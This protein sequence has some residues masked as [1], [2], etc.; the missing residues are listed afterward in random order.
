MTDYTPDPTPTKHC[1]SCDK[2]YPATAEYFATDRSKPDGFVYRCKTCANARTRVLRATLEERKASYDPTVRQCTRCDKVFPATLEYFYAARNN[3]PDALRAT[4][5]PCTGILTQEQRDPDK[6]RIRDRRYAA[7]NRDK[8][9]KSCREWRARNLDTQRKKDRI[10]KQKDPNR[11]E[12]VKA[13]RINNPDK[14]RLNMRLYFTRKASHA[15]DYTESD[16]QFA[17]D[18]FK[19]C[20]AVCGRPPGLFHGL[21]MD[22]WLPNSS[23]DCPG[24]IPANIVPLCNGT[25]GCNQSKHARDPVQWL[26]DKFGEKQGKAILARVHEFFS[27]VRSV[28]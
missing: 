1:P 11:R 2:D 8:R 13:W 9:R 5:K 17:L 12:K 6:S 3:G 23:Q 22:H 25:D 18:Y 19:G 15:V 14:A 28:D 20:C 10:A 16:W 21:A 27:H 4:C 24:M 26:V 7:K